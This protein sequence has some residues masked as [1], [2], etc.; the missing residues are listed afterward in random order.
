MLID[1]HAFFVKST[2]RGWRSTR[3][4]T[5]LRTSDCVILHYPVWSSAALWDRHLAGVWDREHEAV[6]R[7]SE[8]SYHDH[9]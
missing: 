2:A 6:M 8:W 7:T 9:L 4:M 5:K 1:L 3:G